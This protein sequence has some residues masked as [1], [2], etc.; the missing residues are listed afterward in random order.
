[1]V[2]PIIDGLAAL[3]GY[4]G[5]I[6]W[7]VLGVFLAGALLERYDED[8]GV[9]VYAGG[10]VILA[11]Y[12]LAYVHYFVFEMKSITESAGVI[13][14]VPLSLYV[15]YLLVTGRHRL[16]VVSRAVTFV[17]LFFLPLSALAFVRRPLIEMTTSH[18]DLFL[19]LLGDNYR[20]GDWYPA[21]PS[22]LELPGGSSLGAESTLP[23][24]HFPYRNTFLYA[25]DGHPI[26][27]T[28]RLACTGIGSM[29]IF[30]GLI[31]AVRGSL[32]QKA[33]ALGAAIGIIYVLNIVRN[34]FIAHT[35]G[36][37]RL[38]VFPDL[39]LSLFS[40]DDPYLVSYFVGDR[41]LAQFG[42]VIALVAITWLVVR[43]VPDVLRVVEEILYLLTRREY[44]LKG[45]LNVDDREG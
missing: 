16:L 7:V 17:W 27:Y 5:T 6:A 44:D 22:G 19:S 32:R 10:W 40:S 29:S 34:V 9:R 28:I 18:T 2:E 30:V 31:G 36:T 13:V 45:A 15:A 23:D 42:S 4:A 35:V 33:K 8:I 1:M 39:I 14:A 25:P 43:W 41:I 20:L 38:H 24:K 11:G 37:Q 12:W 26:T 3:N 21:L